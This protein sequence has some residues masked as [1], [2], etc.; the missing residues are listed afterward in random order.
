MSSTA[1]KYNFVSTSTLIHEKVY[2]CDSDVYGFIPPVQKLHAHHGVL[3][4]K[5]LWR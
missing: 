3:W 4:E 1:L 5:P 2:Q